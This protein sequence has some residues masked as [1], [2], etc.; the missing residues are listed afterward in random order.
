MRGPL[1][2]SRLQYPLGS[3]D[4]RNCRV[5]KFVYTANLFC[6]FKETDSSLSMPSR[7]CETFAALDWKVSGMH[8]STRDA[9][10]FQSSWYLA[11]ES[12]FSFVCMDTQCR[13]HFLCLFGGPAERQGDKKLVYRLINMFSSTEIFS[14]RRKIYARG[15]EGKPEL[16]RK[17]N[18]RG[19]ASA[20][21]FVH[22]WDACS[23]WLVRMRRLFRFRKTIVS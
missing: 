9:S 2:F 11:C 10:L 7:R 15:F 13:I 16:T 6:V 18:G 14:K 20:L 17:R 3:W 8:A 21:T 23:L 22:M 4:G 5:V 12:I 1:S 19:S